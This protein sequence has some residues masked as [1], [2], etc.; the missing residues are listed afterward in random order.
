MESSDYA[1]IETRLAAI[2]VEMNS[3]RNKRERAMVL[4][5]KLSQLLD[6][7]P[8]SIKPFVEWW[9]MKVDM[10]NLKDAFAQIIGDFSYSISRPYVKINKEY[11]IKYIKNKDIMGLIDFLSKFFE[12]FNKG[13]FENLRSYPE[14][15]YEL[16]SFYYGNFESRYPNDR[17]NFELSRSIVQMKVDLINLNLLGRLKSSR[18]FLPFGL[19]SINHFKDKQSLEKGL[20]E[21]YGVKSIEELK[22]RYYSIC[23]EYD[24]Y[25]ARIMNTIISCEKLIGE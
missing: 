9:I 20:F 19:L 12:E 3:I 13:K 2:E 1:Y 7:F 17:R 25:F 11:I 18:Y 24:S 5:S 6:Y 21:I 16:D 22:E 8:S 4:Y 14:F 10:E 23:N 15:A